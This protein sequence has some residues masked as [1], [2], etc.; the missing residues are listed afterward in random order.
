MWEGALDGAWKGAI[1]G[2]ILGFLVW[3]VQKVM[4]RNRDEDAEE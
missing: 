2:G 1:I 3:L 4:N